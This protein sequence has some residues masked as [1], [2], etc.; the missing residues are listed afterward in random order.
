MGVVCAWV[1]D[2][3]AFDVGVDVVEVVW[4]G[5][6]VFSRGSV[7]FLG[8]LVFR[9]VICSFFGWCSLRHVASCVFIRCQRRAR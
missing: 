3:G 4:R 2:R 5:H 1:P 8:S 7:S 9:V 6:S